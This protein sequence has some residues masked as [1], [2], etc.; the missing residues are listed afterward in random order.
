MDPRIILIAGQTEQI[1][2]LTGQLEDLRKE[3]ARVTFALTAN[4][5]ET[6]ASIARAIGEP[7][8]RFR[9]SV[10]SHKPE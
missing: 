5:D 2:S 4:G 8:I 10:N 9:K 7:E 3:R 1:E 6:I